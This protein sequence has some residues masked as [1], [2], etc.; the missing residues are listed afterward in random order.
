M[1]KL[2]VKTYCLGM[3][4]TNSYV[5][6]AEGSDKCW[7]I[8]AGFDP[9]AMVEDIREKNLKPEFLIY[10]HAHLD[11]IAGTAVIRE[12]FPEIKTAISEAEASFLGDPSKNLS[13][14]AGMNVTADDADVLLSDGQE[15]DF[16]GLVFRVITTP[17]HSPGGICLYQ[18]EAGL[19]FSGDT[20]FQGSVGRYDFPSSNGEDL[21]QSIKEKL[22]SLPDETKTFPGHGGATTI[23]SEKRNNPFF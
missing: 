3:W 5:L 10:T 22:M 18:E 23:G 19:L 7:I 20:L 21:F 1:I 4:Q 14:S 12:A 8:D 11:H 6:S 17:G 2:N 13:S 9:E 15:L 16:E